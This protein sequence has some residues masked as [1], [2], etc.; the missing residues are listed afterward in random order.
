LIP[1]PSL[2]EAS[3]QALDSAR[4]DVALAALA[5]SEL[6]YQHGASIIMRAVD[7]GSADVG[8][9]LR[10]ATVDQIADT[11][12]SGRRMPPKTTFFHPK[13]RTGMVYREL[14]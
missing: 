9:L 3:E 12:H 14:A 2:E 4:L 13:P 1:R 6:T 10:P 8:F 7:E 11:A 5:P